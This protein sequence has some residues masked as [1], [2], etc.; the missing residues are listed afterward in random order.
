MERE[1]IM[2]A[3]KHPSTQPRLFPVIDMEERVPPHHLLRQT[4]EAVDVSVI[5]DGVVPLYTEK[6]GRPAVDPERLLRLILLSVRVRNVS[7][8]A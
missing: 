3:P 6:T 5:H 1:Q 4:N 8:F 2:K 7:L